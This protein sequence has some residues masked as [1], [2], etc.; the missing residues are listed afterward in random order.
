MRLFDKVRRVL[1]RVGRGRSDT[2]RSSDEAGP[3]ADRPAVRQD[4]PSPDTA[5]PEPS[6]SVVEPE[7]SPSAVAPES[8]A[9]QGT[10]VAEDA[11]DGGRTEAEEPAEQTP[12]RY[13]THTIQPNQSLEEVAALHGVDVEQVAELN[14]LDPELIF[15]GQVVRIPHA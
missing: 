5:Q 4:L 2:D 1:A 12:Q 9:T 7:P 10:A 14:G 11:P 13:R 3:T 6:P 15:A 8:P